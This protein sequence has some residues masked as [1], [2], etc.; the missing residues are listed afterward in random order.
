MTTTWHRITRNDWYANGI[1]SHDAADC[2]QPTT[3]TGEVID[4]KHDR[5]DLRD[6]W[7]RK[8][9]ERRAATS[10]SRAAGL[11]ELTSKAASI[12][13]ETRSAVEEARLAGMSWTEIG[14]ALGVSKQ[15]VARK[16]AF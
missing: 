2:P 1:D 3:C 15:A 5:Y 7:M 8:E 4:P 11:R 12:A 14:T 16:Y 10:E 13:S 9:Q 6:G